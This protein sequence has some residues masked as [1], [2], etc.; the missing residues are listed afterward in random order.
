MRHFEQR[1]TRKAAVSRT[2]AERRKR[3]ARKNHPALRP[4]NGLQQNRNMPRCFSRAHTKQAFDLGVRSGSLVRREAVEGRGWR[5]AALEG[6]PIPLQQ[7]WG[8]GPPPSRRVRVKS[9]GPDLVRWPSER[10]SARGEDFDFFSPADRSADTESDSWASRGLTAGGGGA[11][12]R[13]D[14]GVRS[15]GLCRAG[16]FGVREGSRRR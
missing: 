15:R 3:P 13:E 5:A 12:G 6:V 8:L 10:A 1:P 9:E 7:A 16:A 11:D 4:V 2:A 14:G